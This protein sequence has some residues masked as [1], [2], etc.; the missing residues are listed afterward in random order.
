MKQEQSLP[1]AFFLLIFALLLMAIPIEFK[2]DWRGVVNAEAKQLRHVSSVR[3]SGA[4]VRVL[5][6]EQVRKRS[7]EYHRINRD[8]IWSAIHISALRAEALR[9]RNARDVMH[10]QREEK[11]LLAVQ[12]RTPP[13]CPL[14]MLLAHSLQA[15]LADHKPAVD[16]VVHDLD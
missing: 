1:A 6:Q 8:M 9:L 5:V 10:A 14:H 7:A 2:Q 3:D 15:C 11:M 12:P 13:V 16:D 4:Q